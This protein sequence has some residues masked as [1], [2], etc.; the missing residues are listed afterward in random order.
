MNGEMMYGMCDVCG[1]E[2]YLR[3][4]Y[5]YYGIKCECHSPEHFEIVEHCED[6]IPYKPSVTNV[7]IK[8]VRSVTR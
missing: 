4:T 3:R 8:P 5:F 1:K 7:C 2:S 6:C